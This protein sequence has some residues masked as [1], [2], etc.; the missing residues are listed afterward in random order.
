MAAGQFLEAAASQGNL[1]CKLQAG[2]DAVARGGVVREDDVAGLF[3]AEVEPAVA[4]FLQDVTVTHPGFAD[5][6]AGIAEGD[7]QA[8]V[9]HDGGHQDVVLELSG[10]LEGHAPGSP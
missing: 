4:H 6:D 10:L 3:A 1:G 7:L 8:E 9:A 2:Q 5:G